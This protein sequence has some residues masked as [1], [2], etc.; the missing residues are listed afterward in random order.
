MRL[1]VSMLG[2][3][4]NVTNDCDCSWIVIQEFLLPMIDFEAR[5][6]RPLR[7]ASLKLSE[8]CVSSDFFSSL[9]R[10]S[11]TKKTEKPKIRHVLKIR[12]LF[13]TTAHVWTIVLRNKVVSYL[14]RRRQ[15][16]RPSRT[17]LAVF[18][19]H[20]YFWDGPALGR[21]QGTPYSVLSIYSSDK[22]PRGSINNCPLPLIY[23]ML[24]F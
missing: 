10:I 24:I 23:C 4:S 18:R 17:P 6:D 22:L 21:P 12:A 16:K 11:I 7:F 3:D 14:F 1:I 19:Q 9:W 2:E 20:H 13:R 8:T 5:S 15:W